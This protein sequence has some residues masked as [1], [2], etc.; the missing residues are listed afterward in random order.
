MYWLEEKK[1]T[2]F[3]THL[4]Y[5]AYCKRRRQQIANYTYRHKILS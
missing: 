3:A 5:R 2:D 1:I 4:E